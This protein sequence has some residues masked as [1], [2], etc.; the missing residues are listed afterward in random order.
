MTSPLPVRSGTWQPT[1]ATACDDCDLVFSEGQLL[2]PADP[3]LTQQPGYLDS[4]LSGRGA[5][6][7]NGK[8][9]LSPSLLN[10]P[11]WAQNLVCGVCGKT[12]SDWILAQIDRKECVC[13]ICFPVWARVS[14]G[15][16]KSSRLVSDE[17]GGGASAARGS[18]PRRYFL[19]PFLAALVLLVSVLPASAV[20]FVT[21]SYDGDFYTIN[22]VGFLSFGNPLTIPAASSYHVQEHQGSPTGCVNWDWTA[23]ATQWGV[24]PGEVFNMMYFGELLALRPKWVFPLAM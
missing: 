13:R 22:D 5:A 8:S 23:P 14:L 4:L 10:A 20:T 18:A 7:E 12:C 21:D 24:K 2:S 17:S 11:F 16:K 1:E 9:R 15:C 19:K 6:V 3:P